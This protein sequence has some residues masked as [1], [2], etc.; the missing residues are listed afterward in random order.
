MCAGSRL[1]ILRNV[2]KRVVDVL[3]ATDVAARGLDLPNIY[4]VVSYDPARDIETHTH[5]VGRTGRAG[6]EGEAYT[7]L[8]QDDQ[9]KKMAALLVENLEQAKQ[10]VPEDLKA[11]KLISLMA[12]PGSGDEIWALPSASTTVE[13]YIYDIEPVCHL[14]FKHNMN[15]AEQMPNGF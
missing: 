7:L 5:R 3:I 11:S 2:R 15:D 10:V 1:L 6:M 9:N 14:L 13:P 12:V 8:T 4:T